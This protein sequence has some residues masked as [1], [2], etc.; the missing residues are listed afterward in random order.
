MTFQQ[1]EQIAG[2]RRW[3]LV[4]VDSADGVTGKTGQ[5]GTVFISKNGGASVAST[6]SIVEVDAGDMPGHYYVELTAD[7]LDTLGGISISYKSAEALA[8][9]DRAIVGNFKNKA[10]LAKDDITSS[11]SVVSDLKKGFDDLKELTYEFGTLIKEMSD[12]DKRFENMTSVMQ[13]KELTD[14]SNKFD[15]S[16]KKILLTVTEA[17]F[18]VLE[19]IN[20]K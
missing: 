17:K 8:F 16:I 18:D 11:L 9:H 6:N 10:E 12:M 1:S 3:I 2:L 20:N 19:E 5:T 15:E 4:L 14:L 7:E 13:K